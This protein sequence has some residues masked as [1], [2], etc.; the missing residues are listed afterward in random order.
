MK[1]NVLFVCAGNSFRSPLAEALLVRELQR[2]GL[3][4]VQVAS[5]GLSVDGDPD[6]IARESALSSHGFEFES[7]SPRQLT[8]ELLDRANSV[9]V[10]QQRQVEEI[11]SGYH[12]A[13]A[14][15]MLGSW[16]GSSLAPVEILD[17]HDTGDYALVA[18]RI[19]QGVEALARSN[20]LQQSAQITQSQSRD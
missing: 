3:E 9:Y 1:S 14:P 20:S 12:L 7:H 6:K 16:L 5:A 17:P 18:E 8:Q 10:F 15:E 11:L 2:L 4:H 19:S 13:F